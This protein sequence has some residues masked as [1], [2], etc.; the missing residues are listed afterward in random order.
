MQNILSYHIGSFDDH[1]KY[2]VLPF[3]LTYLE[4]CGGSPPQGLT[5]FW[6]SQDKVERSQ[7][8]QN[9]YICQRACIS[10]CNSS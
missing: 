6:M 8:V 10:F 2:Q 3:P 5:V 1:T 9:L 4:A 7:T